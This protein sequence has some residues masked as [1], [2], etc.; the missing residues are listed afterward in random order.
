MFG[1]ESVVKDD[2]A[3]QKTAFNEVIGESA[4]FFCKSADT[5][6]R[7][8][9]CKCFETCKKCAMKMATGGKCRLCKQYFTNMSHCG[10]TVHSNPQQAA[11]N[12]APPCDSDDIEILE[13][14]GDDYE[15]K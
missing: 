1:D 14:R 12:S 5:E 13:K 8:V 10:G 11:N 6:Y 15:R 3:Q 4:C 9:P 7:P 2:D